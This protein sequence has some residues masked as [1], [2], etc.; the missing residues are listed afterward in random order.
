M[1]LE[2]TAGGDRGHDDRAARLALVYREAV[3]ALTHQQG[4]V[5]SINA[6]AGNLIYTTA[7]VSSLLGARA[8][9]D[10]LGVWDWSAL[11]LLLV[12][13]GLVVF[14]IWPYQN[15]TFRFDPDRLLAEFC[16]DEAP[17]TIDAMHRT[18]SSRIK[19]N[20]DDNWRII[21]RLRFGLQLAL[22]LFV[23]NI[24]AWLFAIGK[25]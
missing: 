15:Y 13:G 9:A 8:L 20:L 5:D 1:D 18:L 17:T 2:E 6:R 4:V 11:A 24:V 19:R 23:L 16:D 25:V 12:N 10:G 22:V 14:I 7:F 21:Q 3:R